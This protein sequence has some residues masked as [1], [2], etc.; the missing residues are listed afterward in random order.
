MSTFFVFRRWMYQEIPEELRAVVEP[1]VAAHGLELVDV[2]STGVAG[3]RVLRVTVDT[4]TGDGAVSVES[5][6]AIS[7]ELGTNLDASE[8]VTGVYRLE[9]S[10]PGLDR[11]LAREKDFSA[12]LGREVRVETRRPLDGR[13]RFRGRLVAFDA[14][15]A[16]LRVDGHEFAIPFAEVAK[17]QAVYEFTRADFG[18]GRQDRSGRPS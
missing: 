11:H 18:R 12:A 2:E 3:T 14:G 6:A 1:V 4:P 16:K 13:R 10:S 9:V 5:C 17:A 15:V 8:A 7:R